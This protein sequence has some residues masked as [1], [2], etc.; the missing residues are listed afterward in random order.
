MKRTRS[1]LSPGYALRSRRTL[2]LIAVSR[3]T[4]ISPGRKCVG[5]MPNQP[6]A[7]L[8]METLIRDLR[9][10][11]R[12]LRKNPGFTLIAVLSLAL[13]IGANTAIFSLVEALVLRPVPIHRPEEV[14]EVYTRSPD[15]PYN[16]FSIPDYR[17]FRE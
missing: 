14:V 10:G 13:G 4:R 9:Y 6:P 11:L 17:E 5:R 7:G 3:L 16:V 1:L 2:R 15:F 8:R 12:R